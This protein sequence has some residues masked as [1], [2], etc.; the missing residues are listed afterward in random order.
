MSKSSND[1]RTKSIELVVAVILGLLSLG[2]FLFQIFTISEKTTGLESTL[3]NL[4]QLILTIGFA[5][6]TTRAISR[7]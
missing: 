2:C 1:S 3:F 4:L 6:F 7:S 5:W